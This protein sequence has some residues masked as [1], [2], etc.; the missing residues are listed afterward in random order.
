MRLEIR[1]TMFHSWF[2]GFD[3]IKYDIPCSKLFQLQ[4]SETEPIVLQAKRRDRVT[5]R[6]GHFDSG[7]EGQSARYQD[8]RTHYI[9]YGSSD[10]QRSVC[11]PSRSHWAV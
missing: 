11:E 10:G 4:R 8:R 7:L 9:T 5:V 6:S 3:H 2:M 1:S